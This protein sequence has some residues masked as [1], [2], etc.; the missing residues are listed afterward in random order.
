M[1]AAL[2]RDIRAGRYSN[3][4]SVVVMRHGRIAWEQ[5]FSG[6][7]ERRGTAAGN[8]VFGPNV[9]HDCRS[10]TKS[11]VSILFGI[12]VAEGR[13]PNLDAPV[14]DHFPEF[15][16]LR[17][18]ERL[19]IR[20]RHVLAMSSG[21]EW[22]ESSRP[23]GDPANSETAMDA[24]PNRLRYI[25]ERP[26]AA[27]PG[28]RWTYN[29]GNTQL[30]VSIIERVTGMDVERYAER[31]LFRPLGIRRHEWLR[32]PD[33]K[34]IAASGLRLLPRDMARIGQLYLQRGRWNG[35]QIVPESWVSASLSPQ[36][37]IA[38]RPLGLQRYGY[39]WYLGTARLGER[40]L[41]YSAAIGYGGQRI[42]VMPE[43]DMVMVLTAGLYRD[44]RQSDIA[45]E[46][47][48]DRVL[49]AT[50]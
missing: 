31:T 39:Q 23:Y 28:Q 16:D 29:G 18:P 49:P 9:L 42:V 36:V 35:R 30:L 50:R 11:I 25:L 21:F 38:D 32:Y 6:P 47:L 17:T 33:G 37:R 2:A 48:L 26:I 40:N 15:A 12:A 34:A 45:F 13:I 19:A 1:L 5:Y 24:A 8:V 3:I 4:H 44:P 27:A 10:V 20:V 43:M 7:D 22:N 14:L 41:P 46:I